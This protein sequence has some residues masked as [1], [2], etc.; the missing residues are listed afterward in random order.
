[1]PTERGVAAARGG[2]WRT[3]SGCANLRVPVK[4]NIGSCMVIYPLGDGSVDLLDGRSDIAVK[5][6]MQ[7]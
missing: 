1:M 6:A 4:S 3:V 2:C 7:F 5:G